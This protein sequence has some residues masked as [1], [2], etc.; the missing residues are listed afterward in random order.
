MSE[1]QSNLTELSDADLAF[2]T[3]GTAPTPMPSFD[4]EGDTEHWFSVCRRG[5]GQGHLQSLQHHPQV[6]HAS[7]RDLLL[8]ELP[9]YHAEARCHAS[10]SKGLTS[11]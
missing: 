9:P 2:I 1:T 10:R 7:L 6:D 4:I 3:G 5:H 11:C 8:Q